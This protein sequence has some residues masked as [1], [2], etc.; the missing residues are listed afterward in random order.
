M[1]WRIKSLIQRTVAK[2][3]FGLSDALYL[4]LQKAYGNLRKETESRIVT[5]CRVADAAKD[6]LPGSTLLEVGTGRRLNVPLILWLLGAENI[7][8]VDLNRYLRPELVV[9]DM[10]HYRNRRQWLE[11]NLLNSGG[12][13]DCVKRLDQLLSLRMRGGGIR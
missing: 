13:D 1:N 9:A 5:A 3:P 10:D 7:T 2:L 8:S 4:Q 12:S 11:D 6:R